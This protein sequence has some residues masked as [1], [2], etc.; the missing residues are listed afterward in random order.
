[1]QYY[2]N[3]CRID[4]TKAEFLYSIDKFDR[5]LCRKHQ[6]IE[7]KKRAQST[8]YER[9]EKIFAEQNLIETEKGFPTDMSEEQA[10]ERE[11]SLAKKV[12]GTIG[13]GVVTGVKKLVRYSKKQRQIRK[14]KNAILRRMKMSHL[15]NLCFEQKVSIK[16]TELREDKNGE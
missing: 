13:R 6:A 14:W 9:Q 11:K 1:M 7:R 4:I 3:I 16:K 2:C 12:A 15:K 8:Q 5:P 10:S